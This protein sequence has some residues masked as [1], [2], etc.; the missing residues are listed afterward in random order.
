MRRFMRWCFNSLIRTYVF[1]MFRAEWANQEPLLQAQ[2]GAY[3][4]FA[5][6]VNAQLDR[7]KYHMDK[8]K[9]VTA[10]E[11]MQLKERNLAD[12][13]TILEQNKRINML[14]LVGDVLETRLALLEAKQVK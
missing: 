3:S 13:K 14:I 12:R 1:E 6:A 4:L 10:Q 8:V 7:V 5:D 2:A 11:I 9:S